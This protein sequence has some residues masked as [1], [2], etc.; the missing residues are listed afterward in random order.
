MIRILLGA[1]QP[2][3]RPIG[4]GVTGARRGTAVFGGQQRGV[5]VKNGTAD[6]LAAECFCALLANDL[7]VQA[8]A[9][10]LVR[11]PDDGGVLFASVDVQT[12]NLLQALNI[13]SL[14]SAEELHALAHELAG[15]LGFGRLLALDVLLRNADRNAGNLL[16]DGVDWWAIDHAR[17]LG[18]HPW[19]GHP[20]YGLVT[21]RCDAMVAAGVEASAV[22]N[23]LTF[24]PGCHI[25]SEQDLVQVGLSAH[26]ANFAG[27]II[28][29]LPQLATTMSAM[30]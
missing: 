8:P 6:E 12:P 4:I 15:W 13:T 18:L 22:S 20:L 28:A 27:Q 16:T 25:L 19:R 29:R 30:L 11:D 10:G 24:G 1:L 3:S 17:S 26:A 5:I 21:Q 23:A 7:H 14:A 2:G 9:C